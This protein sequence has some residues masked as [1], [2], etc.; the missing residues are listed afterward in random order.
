MFGL[1]LIALCQDQ[2][3]RTCPIAD[4]PVLYLETSS[5]PH[6]KWGDV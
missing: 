3:E 1:S 2:F 4:L 5:V 6:R